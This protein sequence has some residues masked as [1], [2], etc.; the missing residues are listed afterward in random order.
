[1]NSCWL[2]AIRDITKSVILSKI[3][4]KKF[5]MSWTMNCYRKNIERNSLKSRYPHWIKK[6]KWVNKK[7]NI[8]VFIFKKS[9]SWRNN[10]NG[11]RY[12]KTNCIMTCQV[13]NCLR[14]LKNQRYFIY[15]AKPTNSCWQSRLRYLLWGNSTR[16]ISPSYYNMWV[17]Q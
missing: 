1:M 14:F 5:G 15:L 13:I 12:R 16:T 17:H 8:I 7:K 10:F 11:R 9:H 6:W 2:R 3:T 4:K